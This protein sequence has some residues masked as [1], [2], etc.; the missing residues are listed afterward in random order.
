[1]WLILCSEQDVSA[2][3]AYQGLG[4]RDL[5]PLELVSAEML[6][7]ALRWDHRVSAANTSV[8]ITLADGRVITNAEVRG[9]LNRLTYVPLGHLASNP[10]HDYASQEYTAFFMSWLG[11]FRHP[12]LNPASAQGLSGAWRHISEWVWLAARAGLPTPD[13]RQTSSDEVDES[14]ELRKLFPAGTPT[15]TNIVVE[16]KVLGPA[17][18]PNIRKGCVRLAKLSGTPLL[19]V[20]L[21]VSASAKSWE[22]AGATPAPDLRLGGEALLDALAITLSRNGKRR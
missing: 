17:L 20:E 15:I 9:V 8:S 18:P 2:L 10:D 5:W 3:W 21:A 1:M 4:A 7:F 13:Y 6:P 16:N 12:V 11:S 22:F 19:G 14:I